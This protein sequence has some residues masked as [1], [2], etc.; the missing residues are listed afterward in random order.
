MHLFDRIEAYYDKDKREELIDITVADLVA[1][2]SKYPANAIVH[3]CGSNMGYIHTTKD[4]LTIN[5]DSVLYKYKC[6]YDRKRDVLV[7][8]TSLYV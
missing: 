2:L 1:L 6:N 8:S 3:F 5:V 4:N 7:C